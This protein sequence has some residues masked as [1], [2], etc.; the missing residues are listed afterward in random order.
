ML[1][2]CLFISQKF[3]NETTKSTLKLLI[4]LHLQIVMANSPQISKELKKKK[5]INNRN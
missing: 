5:Q 1:F 4:E 3:Y 2:M